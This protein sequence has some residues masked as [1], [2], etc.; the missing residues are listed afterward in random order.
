M[1]QFILEVKSLMAHGDF[2]GDGG[3]GVMIDDLFWFLAYPLCVC[4]RALNCKNR[5]A[6]KSEIEVM[7]SSR[8]KVRPKYRPSTMYLNLY[9][10]H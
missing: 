5:R 8:S 9:S 10:M 1:C 4:V 6:M 7:H 3:Y 2:I